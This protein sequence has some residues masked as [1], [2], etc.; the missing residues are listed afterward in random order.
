MDGK[1][2]TI[3]PGG[4]RESGFSLVEL[5]LLASIALVAILA[6]LTGVV[7]HS[8]HRRGTSERMLAATAC[9]NTLEE[10]RMV[11]FATLPGLHGSGFDVP[12]PEGEPGGLRPRAGDA[13]GLPGEISIVEDQRVGSHVLYRVQVRVAW[14]GAVTST[15]TMQCLMGVRR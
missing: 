12:G 7:Q 15:I 6:V 4:C 13:D 11:D 3:E 5:L 9:R 10:L 8:S 14:R 1:R 2:T